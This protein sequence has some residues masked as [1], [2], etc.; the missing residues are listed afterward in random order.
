[1][2]CLVQQVL[3]YLEF[4]WFWF[5]FCKTTCFY[6]FIFTFA[7]FFIFTKWLAN[8]WSTTV[9]FMQGVKMLNLN[10]QCY[11]GKKMWIPTLCGNKRAQCYQNRHR[12]DASKGFSDIVKNPRKSTQVAEWCVYVKIYRTSFFACG[13]SRQKTV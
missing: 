11:S 12:P 13:K 10:W 4:F 3:N 2:V 5:R 6:F 8:S 9:Q 7:P 1:M